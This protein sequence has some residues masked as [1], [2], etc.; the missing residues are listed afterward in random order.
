MLRI[1]NAPETQETQHTNSVT[2]K[3]RSNPPIFPT[4]PDKPSIIL[5]VAS[6][7]NRLN[8]PASTAEEDIAILTTLLREYRRQLGENPVGDNIEITAALL[9]ANTKNLSYLPAES[10][11]FLDN[12]GQLIDRWEI[13]YFF[14]SISGTEMDIIS[15]GPD[16]I[17]HTADDL[18]S[19]QLD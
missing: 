2:E 14:H 7:A 1:F 19:E 13:P 15:A 16:R 5:P 11:N 4:S 8:D 12:S 6:E 18:S 17:L 10:G 3:S 9:G